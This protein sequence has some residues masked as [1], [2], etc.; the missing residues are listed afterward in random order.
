MLL[1]SSTEDWVLS[2][3]MQSDEKYEI[4]ET[5]Q[6]EKN[7]LLKN[8]KMSSSEVINKFYLEI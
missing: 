3:A 6:V 2:Q 5:S 1:E 7:N 4:V 8:Q